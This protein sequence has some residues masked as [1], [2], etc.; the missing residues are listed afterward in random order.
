MYLLRRRWRRLSC[1]ARDR[2]PRTPAEALAGTPRRARARGRRP[3]D[4][5]ASGRARRRRSRRRPRRRPPR[6]L[7]RRPG[8]RRARRPPR[9]PPPPPP[10][11][12]SAVRRGGQ[13]REKIP[14]WA[15]AALQP[16]PIWVVHV[17]A[18]ADRAAGGRRRPARRRR[19]GLRQL[20]VCH[21]ATARA[22]SG[23]P[24]ADGEVLQDVPA[25]RGPAALRLLRHG[26]VQ[27][28][29]RRRSTATPNREGGAARDRV[30][31]PDAG[32]GS[33][34]RRRADRRG[35]P[36]RRVPRALH[37]RRRRPDSD[38]YAEEFEDWCSEEAPTFVALEEGVDARRARRPGARTTPRA[39]RSRSS[40]SA[41]PRRRARRRDG[42]R[43]AVRRSTPID[44]TH[45]GPRRRRRARPARPPATGWPATA[46]TSRSSS[47]RRSPARRRAATA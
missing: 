22:A 6:R 19:R 35:D 5:A 9:R 13:A 36:R 31:R 12:D 17:R 15:M 29:R 10:K 14:F 4:A 37:A 21:G 46:T 23:R 39:S 32:P 18:L 33:E 11:P 38:E 44:V 16:V 25:H 41:T 27:H 40:T 45:R 8:R 3:A 43:A 47:A 7:P 30:A 24:F 20:L 26:R 2:D 42:G 28:R 1:A 34:R